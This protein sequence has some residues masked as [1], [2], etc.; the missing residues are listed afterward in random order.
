MERILND[1]P[2]IPVY[3]DPDSIDV[4]TPN[5]LLRLRDMP[6]TPVAYVDLRDRYSRQWRQA[7]LLADTFWR[8]WTKEYLPTLQRRQ[9]WFKSGRN[10]TVGDLVLILDEK[11]PRGRWAKGVVVDASQELDGLVRELRIRTSSGVVHRDIRK[12]SLLEG[13]EDRFDFPSH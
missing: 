12:V 3:D 10:F 11:Q 9:K 4:L 13:V 1:R 7:Q 8:R 6:D 2:L 5:H